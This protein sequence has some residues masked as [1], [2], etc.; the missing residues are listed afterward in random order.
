MQI[1]LAWHHVSKIA[2]FCHKGLYLNIK[3]QMERNICI[4][5]A[6]HATY[7]MN[8]LNICYSNVTLHNILTCKVVPI[9]HFLMMPIEHNDGCLKIRQRPT[10]DSS[11]CILSV[12]EEFGKM[13]TC[14]QTLS[15]CRLLQNYC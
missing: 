12:T 6:K 13:H 14:A 9:I 1:I 11:S 3:F 5:I 10:L 2:L 7:I 4:Y 8:V 15:N